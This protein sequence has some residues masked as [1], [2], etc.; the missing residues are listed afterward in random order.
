MLS[1]FKKFILR[2][3]VVDLAVGVVVGAAFSAF[4]AALV[5]D[6]LTPFI[7]ALF[8]APDFSALSFTINGSKFLYGDLLNALLSLL[9]VSFAVYFFV[10]LPVNALI[11]RLH[12]EPVLEPTTKT[13]P[14]CATDIP[15]KAGRCPHCTSVLIKQS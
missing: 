6:L 9:I 14:E 2:G 8:K 13:C 11:A 12:K 7:A 4:I 3:N 5:K 15:L 1:G 10:V